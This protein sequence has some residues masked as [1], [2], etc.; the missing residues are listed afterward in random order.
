MAS[1]VGVIDSLES[2]PYKQPNNLKINEHDDNLASSSNTIKTATL[3]IIKPNSA[4]AI[5]LLSDNED[6]H[7][8]LQTNNKSLAL[9]TTSHQLYSEAANA[10][11]G[12]ETT[13][14]LQQEI[15]QQQRL[16]SASSTL[17]KSVSR[18]PSSAGKRSVL[19]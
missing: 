18:N 13:S 17:D 15:D 16:K 8:N 10:H 12:H 3:T 1:E 19:N 9:P 5:F 2:E 6:T 4:S 7:S 14:F 11:G